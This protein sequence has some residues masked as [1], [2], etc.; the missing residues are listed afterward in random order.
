R[1]GELGLGRRVA[2]HADQ[3]GDG[4]ALD[5]E[6]TTVAGDLDLEAVAEHGDTVHGLRP[7]EVV[8]ADVVDVVLTEPEGL[9]VRALER[10]DR[11]VGPDEGQ[12][13]DA[14]GRG[15]PSAEVAV[16]A[17]Q[18]ARRSGQRVVADQTLGSE[19]TEVVGCGRAA[20]RQIAPG[21]LDGRLSAQITGVDR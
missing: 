20:A 21:G 2:G 6:D 10:E 5:R 7:R 15:R 1:G 11:Q 16:Q 8:H 19:G 12:G 18:V 13:D 4:A 3:T 14:S 9:Q 17:P